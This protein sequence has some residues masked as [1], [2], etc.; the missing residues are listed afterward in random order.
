MTLRFLRPGALLL[1]TLTVTRAASAQDTYRTYFNTRF[2]TTVTYPI[3]LVT[4]R[5]EPDNGDG[6]KFVSRD[7]QIELTVYG[8]H[9]SFSHSVRGEMARAA[10]DWKRDGARLTY[11][12]AGASWFALSGYLGADIFY[13]KT[14]LRNGVFHTLI[15]QYPKALK[16][17]LDAS[18]SRSVAT[19]SVGT[20]IESALAPPTPIPKRV[21]SART[22]VPQPIRKPRFSPKKRP[23]SQPGAAASGY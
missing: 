18:V 19:F 3:N 8:F 2:G 17:R 11:S 23:A 21:P 4:P 1:F 12:K 22:T 15:W 20:G 6:R 10:S 16:Q 7:G 9:N 5:P 13:E 14:L